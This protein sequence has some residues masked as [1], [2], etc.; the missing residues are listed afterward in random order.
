MKILFVDT[1]PVRRGAQ[2]FVEELSSQLDLLGLVTKRVYLFE[3]AGT[4]S[5]SLRRQDLVLPY[6]ESSFFEKIPSFHPGLLRSLGGLVEEFDPDILL[7]NGSRTLKYAAWLRYF[8]YVKGRRLVGR[9]IDDAEFW[10]PGGI[11]KWAYTQWIGQ[12]DGI[13]AVSAAS[14]DSV[15][16]HYSFPGSTRVIHRS[17]DRNKFGGVPGREEARKILGL[18]R[19]D[20]VLL[21]LGNLTA[22]KRPDKFLQIVQSLAQTRPQLKAL[23]VGD[24]TLRREL[25]DQVAYSRGRESGAGMLNTGFKPS[26]VIFSGYQSDV[27]PFISAAD[28]LV[29]TSDTEG[30]PGVVLE[31]AYLEVP[32]VATEVGGIR[33]CLLDGET[34]ILVPDR[35]VGTFCERIESLLDDS[36]VRKGMGRKARVFVESHFRM[37]SIAG[38]YLDFFGK[39]LSST[40]R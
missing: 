6:L 31:A 38:Q 39:I 25:E 35:S 10:N 2:V 37:E 15:V 26:N 17:F 23:L 19:N 3:N 12:L 29:L 1:S 28:I 40:S 32:T 33:E 30:L 9:F 7:F 4:T 34:G 18:T 14:L 24:G 21:F 13:V 11:K 8:G 5:V 20:E 22:Q 27:G 36:S 16:R